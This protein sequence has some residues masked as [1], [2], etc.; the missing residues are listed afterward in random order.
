MF[1]E[2]LLTLTIESVLYILVKAEVSRYFGDASRWN[3]LGVSTAKA[4]ERKV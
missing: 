1:R 4:I 2:M 3:A